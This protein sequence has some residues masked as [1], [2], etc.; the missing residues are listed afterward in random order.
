MSRQMT[1]IAGFQCRDGLLM[2]ADMEEGSAA[3]KRTINKLFYRSYGTDYRLLLTGAGSSAVI[4]NA[5]ERTDDGI[6]GGVDAT[7]AAAIQD[8]IDSVLRSVYEKYVWPNLH[9][10][11]SIRLLI[12]HAAPMKQQLW[13]TTDIVTA[14]E[15][16][17]ACAGIGEDLANYFADRLYHPHYSEQQMVRLATLIF[18]EVKRNVV[19]VGQGTQM[20]MLRDI[21]PDQ[22]YPAHQIQVIEDGLPPLENML[23]EYGAKITG[24]TIFPQLPFVLD[25]PYVE[26]V[27]EDANKV[28]TGPRFF[29]PR[30]V[31]KLAF[32]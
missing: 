11:H 26:L 32:K 17:Y 25:V 30:T 1:L 8:L 6:K 14:P 12:A 28:L 21:G 31:K 7:N 3:S 13:V 16:R 20:W 27:H 18:K 19:G 2:C 24:P 22:F 29:R 5:I 9:T 4:D 23:R 15:V 10:D